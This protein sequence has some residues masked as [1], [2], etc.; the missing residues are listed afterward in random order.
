MVSYPFL[1][2]GAKRREG[3]KVFC[4]QYNLCLIGSAYYFKAPR[5]KS[6]NYLRRE[7]KRS[8]SFITNA[9]NKFLHTYQQQAPEGRTDLEY[10]F[11]FM[12][13]PQRG[14]L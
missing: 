13:K 10:N 7:G 1:R 14:A 2:K 5:F 9:K 4:V 6:L 3:A 12:I 8:N 11:P